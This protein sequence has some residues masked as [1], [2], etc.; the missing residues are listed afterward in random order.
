MPSVLATPSFPHTWESSIPP[1]NHPQPVAVARKEAVA[2]QLG[3]KITPSQ[4]GGGEPTASHRPNPDPWGLLRSLGR[5]YSWKLVPRSS[6]AT[7]QRLGLG[8]GFHQDQPSDFRS[9][10]RGG[11]AEPQLEILDKY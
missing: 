4:L 10:A 8:F 6:L 11:A 3:C 7:R 9:C 2:A 1:L 5:A